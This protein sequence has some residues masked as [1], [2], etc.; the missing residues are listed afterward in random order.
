MTF[1]KTQD[2]QLPIKLVYNFTF[3]R[4]IDSRKSFLLESDFTLPFVTPSFLI[5]KAK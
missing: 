5:L 2:S 4:N 3:F 1:T